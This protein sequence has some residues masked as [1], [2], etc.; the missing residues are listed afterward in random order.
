MTAT[1][2]RIGFV[3]HQFREVRVE[4]AGIQ[5]RYGKD[6]RDTGE[7]PVETFFET[8]DDAD[9]IARDR[10]TLLKRDSRRFKQDV[11]RIVSLA[12]DLDYSQVTPTARVIDTRREADH[13]GVVSAFTIDLGA[14]RTGFETWGAP[15]GSGILT[16]TFEPVLFNADSVEMS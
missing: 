15:A 10:F 11:N 5:T 8:V 14:R 2:G 3:I 1:P 6:A 16:V 4:Y 7:E 12:G 13:L 9:V